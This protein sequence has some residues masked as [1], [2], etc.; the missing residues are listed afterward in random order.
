MRSEALLNRIAD[1]GIITMEGKNAIIQALDPMHDVQIDHLVGWPDMETAPSIV[2]CIKQTIQV[3]NTLDANAWDL[4]IVV[5][6]FMNA[7]RFTPQITRINNFIGNSTNAALFT[8]VGNTLGGLTMYK[9]A[10]GADCNITDT[11]IATISLN[12]SFVH[13]PCRVVGL[14]YEVSNTT[15]DLYKSGQ[16]ICYRLPQPYNKP[17]TMEY[18]APINLNSVSV[19]QF[20]PPVKNAAQAMLIAGTRQWEARRGLYQVVPL[21]AGPENPPLVGDYSQPAF[22]YTGGSEDQPDGDLSAP[23]NDG[24]LVVPTLFTTSI[25]VTGNINVL[26]CCRIFPLQQCGSLFTGL[27]AQ[28]TL[29]VT[30]NVFMETFPGMAELT[31]LTLATPSCPYDPVA[32]QCISRAF[33]NLPVGVPFA[34]NGL[35]EAFANTLADMADVIAPIALALG[36]PA[37]AAAV[38]GGGIVARGVGN[39]LAA[40]SPQ[41]QKRVVSNMKVVKDPYR[42]DAA[43]R[44]SVSAPKG[45]NQQAQRQQAGARKKRANRKKKHKDVSKEERAVLQKF[46]SGH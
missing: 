33:L 22:P 38:S 46:L 17:S 26:P 15:A 23:I 1:A 14:G 13:G 18:S 43:P 45:R 9:T 8:T 44:A 34:D 24:N 5:N 27:T 6:P 4:H 36:Q 21:I 7:T 32:L 29:T 19:Q 10:V 3:S 39:Y 12:D 16:V 35:G 11:P 20:R 2:Q 28:S 42:L 31:L 41:E 30:L 25:P 37:I 40:P